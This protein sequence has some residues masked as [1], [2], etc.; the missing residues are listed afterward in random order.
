MKA[1]AFSDTHTLFPKVDASKYMFYAGDYESGANTPEESAAIA[2]LFLNWYRKQQGQYKVLVPGN[3]DNMF[4]QDPIGFRKLCEANGVYLLDNEIVNLDGLRVFGSPY[5]YTCRANPTLRLDFPQPGA[6]DVMVTHVPPKGI[7][8]FAQGKMENIGSQELR[9]YVQANKPKLHFFGHCHEAYNTL[10]SPFYNVALRSRN[11][12][13]MLINKPVSLEI[14]HV[15]E[16][17]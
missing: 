13:K 11:N 7:L 14:S 12:K 2:T 16:N 10:S 8:D 6:F 17:K 4:W 3:H 9:D 5:F 1:I 15:L